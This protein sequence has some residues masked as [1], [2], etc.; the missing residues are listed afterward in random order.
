MIF[1]SIDIYADQWAKW[2]QVNLKYLSK[3]K[4]KPKELVTDQISGLKEKFKWSNQKILSDPGV[5]CWL[6]KLH[7]DFVLVPADKAANDIIVICKKYYIDTL[8][9]ELGI[10]CLHQ[11]NS[12]YVPSTDS[13]DKVFKGH[14]DF[15]KSVRLKL[16]EEDQDGPYLY[17][18]PKLHILH[19]SIQN[20]V[21]LLVQANAQQ[22]SC[23]AC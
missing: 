1:E 3:W 23:H 6:H 9:K 18:T 7:E 10:N 21:L 12:S 17:W 5:K 2:E 15:F 4:E 11:I 22:K 14:S 20:T 13:Y 19:T 16:S 8:I